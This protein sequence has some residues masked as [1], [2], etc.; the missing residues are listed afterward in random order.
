VS[1][2]GWST[3]ITEQ[4]PSSIITSIPAHANHM[5]VIP[6]Q[7]NDHVIVPHCAPQADKLGNDKQKRRTNK[8]KMSV[9]GTCMLPAR[10][11]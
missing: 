4:T 5:S 1:V 7:T 8:Q 11:N 9:G 2:G 6:G 3:F 10:L